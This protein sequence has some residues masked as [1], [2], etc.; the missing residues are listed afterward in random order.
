MGLNSSTIVIHE[1][2]NVLIALRD[3]EAGERVV[4]GD[5]EVI[6]REDVPAGHK[7][8]REP[9][10]ENEN[11]IKFGMP[12]GRAS[13]PIDRGEWIHTHNVVTG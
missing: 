10:Q 9:I 13:E 11:V 1:R 4:D 3:F 12:I 7:I 5:R 2:D 8:A 6:L